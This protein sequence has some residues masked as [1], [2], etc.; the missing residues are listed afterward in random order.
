VLLELARRGHQLEALEESFITAN[1]ARPVGIAVDPGT[2]EHRSGV[3]ALR[4]A[5][6]VGLTGAASGP[7][8][9]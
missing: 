3:D 7:H 8:A 4:M 2:G 1:F 9:K 6:A 5:A